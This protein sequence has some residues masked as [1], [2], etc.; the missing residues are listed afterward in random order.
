MLK[1]LQCFGLGCTDQIIFILLLSDHE[2][3]TIDGH[4]VDETNN[5]AQHKDE[6]N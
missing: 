1:S 6:K 4:I 3:K 5:T 2:A